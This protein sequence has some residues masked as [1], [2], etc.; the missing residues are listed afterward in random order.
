LRTF[1]YKGC[2]R[3][4]VESRSLSFIFPPI[5]KDARVTPLAADFSVM[6]VGIAARQA[7]SATAMAF[8]AG[9]SP[10][11]NEVTPLAP[12]HGA[13]NA[14]MADRLKRWKESSVR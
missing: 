11:P 1:I 8:Q 4:A 2:C 9:V 7:A 12:A 5:A 14:A 10:V 6:L 13:F 3:V